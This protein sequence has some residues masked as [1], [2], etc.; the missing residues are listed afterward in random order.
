M[1]EK[2]VKLHRKNIENYPESFDNDT[3]RLIQDIIEKTNQTAINK[4]DEV[5]VMQ[6][7]LNDP[8]FKIALND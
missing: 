8:N 2:A 3:D 5:T 4:A 6:S 7:M 1:N